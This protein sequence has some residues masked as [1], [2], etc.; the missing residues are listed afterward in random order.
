MCF[1]ILC[2]RLVCVIKKIDKSALKKKERKAYE[3]EEKSVL[4]AL[5]HREVE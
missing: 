1:F 3:N 5:I 2:R 4:E